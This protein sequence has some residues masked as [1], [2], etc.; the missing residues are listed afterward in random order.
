M[1]K[2]ISR[3]VT[4]RAVTDELIEKRMAEFVISS[5]AVD[6]YG[7]VFRK[8]G[9]KLDDY[10]KN[11][12]V[13]YNHSL[14]SSDPDSIIGTSEVFFDGDQLVGRVEFEQA[15]VNPLAE[16]VFKK[17]QAGTLKMASV[18][19]GVEKAHF[20][21]E[22]R[23]EDPSVMYFTS[24]KLIEWSVVPAGANPDAHKRNKKTIQDLKED[25]VKDIEVT[26]EVVET[27]D[28]SVVE[29]QLIINKNKVK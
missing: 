29:A 11:P 24:Q 7:T 17:I 16:K 26:D 19:A 15:D 23:G 6:S 8:D 14:Y 13:T 5:E 4:L 25:L 1:N 18:G 3:N 12:I 27:K 20:G 2:T 10:L 21:D 9:W 28:R 22:E